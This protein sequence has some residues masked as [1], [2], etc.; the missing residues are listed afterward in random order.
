MTTATVSATFVWR[1]IHSLCGLWLALFLFEH[2]LTNSQAALWIGNDGNGFVRMVNFIHDLPYLEAIEIFLIGVPLLFH[3]VLGIKYL[4]SGKFNAHKTDGSKPALPE[5]GRNRAYSWQRITSWILVFFI[6]FHVVKFRFLEYPYEA[7]QGS[8]SV[9]LVR[10]KMDNGLYTLADRLEITMYDHRE[11]EK[12]QLAMQTR[13]VESAL[14]EAS[15]SI[16]KYD[17]KS[18]EYDQEKGSILSAAQHYEQKKK[19]VETLKSFSIGADEM[20]AVSDSFGKATL[21]TV[22]DAFKN[23]VYVALYTV[24]VLTA[25]F[26]AFNGFWTFLI[27]WGVILNMTS[28]KR[29]G[30][31]AIGLMAF[32]ACMGLIAIWGTYWVNLKH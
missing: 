15:K 4:W 6:V 32:V 30:R 13:E 29:M 16:R 17:K 1:R 5:Y 22:R 23:P 12:E 21:L 11:I 8:K 2:L 24:F 19:F 28:Q 18:G 10:V 14:V 25:C 20:V 31:F 27:T 3:M 7:V 26:H 9:Y